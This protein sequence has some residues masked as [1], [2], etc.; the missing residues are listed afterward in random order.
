[1]PTAPRAIAPGEIYHIYNRGAN[2]KTLFHN[3]QDYNRFVMK[4]CEYKEKFPIEIL[5]YCL[6][7][8]HFHFLIREPTDPKGRG[9]PYGSNITNF[10]HRLATSYSKYYDHRYE[11]HSGR[12]FQ[13]TF[14]TKHVADDA[15]YSQLCAYIHDNPVRK[16][17]AD[18]PAE[19]PFS[20][21]AALVGLRDDN[22]S[23]DAPELRDSSHARIYADFASSRA[24]S[25][26][27]ARQYL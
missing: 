7:P 18:K 23:S 3:D 14:K 9:G 11:H 20:S 25:L 12:V 8:N 4:M 26:E 6:M 17:L 2:K 15:Y 10:L 24:D 13:G 27:L 22:L 19:W 1:M 21:Y 5:A 16:K